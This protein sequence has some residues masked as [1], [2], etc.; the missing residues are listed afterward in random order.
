MKKFVSVIA[1][2][3]AALAITATAG[4]YSIETDLGFGWSTSV[5][6]S[7]EEFADVTPDTV[8]TFTYTVDETLADLDGQ[9]YWCIKPMVDDAGWPFIKTLVGATLSEGGDSYVIDMESSS[10]S[11]TIPAEELELVQNAGMAIMG[12]GIELHEMTF[13]EAPAATTP[14]EDTTV[15]DT[16]ATDKGNPD[17][18]VE[19]VAAVAGAALVAAGAL[20]LTK[21]R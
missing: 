11:F 1:M 13:S 3:A 12:H 14:A 21:K 16:P 18:G 17:T 2:A 6:I 10:M 4:A 7:S 5:Q 8:V 9:N 19:G 20:F 15:T